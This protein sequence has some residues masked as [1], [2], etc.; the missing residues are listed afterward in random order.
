MHRLLAVSS[1]A[2]LQPRRSGSIG[3]VR[4][5]RLLEKFSNHGLDPRVFCDNYRQDASPHPSR[6][7]WRRWP[8]PLRA[9]HGKIQTDRSPMCSPGHKGQQG[10]EVSVPWGAVYRSEDRG[11]QGPHCC[12]PLEA[13]TRDP[14]GQGGAGEAVGVA[15]SARGSVAGSRNDDGRDDPG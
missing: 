7:P 13:W 14:R 12:G 1:S 8:N 6:L 5:S 4:S 2:F 3:L 15:A 11:R 10:T 9:M